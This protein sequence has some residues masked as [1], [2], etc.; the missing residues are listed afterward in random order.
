MRVIAGFLLTAI[1]IFGAEYTTYIGDS[2]SYTVTAMV[3][4]AVGNTYLA[5]S[6]LII[7]TLY[8][9]A[10]TTV[11]YPASDVFVTKLD[12][13]G[14]LLFTVAFAG[15]ISDQAN[16]IA[17]DPSGNIY[18]AGTTYSP[19]FP[20]SNALQ[21]AFAPLGSSFIMKLSP[22]G[23]TIL[24]STFFGG[25][26]P[27]TRINA[28]A[29]DAKGNLYLT[30]YTSASDFPM[31]SGM[32]THSLDPLTVGAFVTEISAAGDK[33]IYSAV[34]TGTRNACSPS[35]GCPARPRST[36]GAGIAVDGGGN[37][38]IAGNTSTTDLA[39]S[40]GAFAAQGIG[41]F[42][43]KIYAGGTGVSYLTYLGAGNYYGPLIE[44][45]TNTVNAV[46]VDSGGSVYLAGA[47]SDPSFPAT[48]GAYQTTFAGPA[49]MN[50]SQA[51]PSDA[52]LAKL[53]PTGT[54]L[55]WATY[56]GGAGMDS[57]NSIAVDADGTVWAVGATT[58]PDFPNANGWLH[59]GNFLAGLSESG[60][61]LTYAAQYPSG[62]VATSVAVDAGGLV[63]AAGPT[64]IVTTIAPKQPP[65]MRPFAIT[66]A[67]GGAVSGRIAR[68]ELISIYGPHIGPSTPVSAMP[69]SAGDLPTSL[70]GIQVTIGGIQAW[71][72]YVSDSQI[73]A[74][75][76]VLAN[77]VEG[78]QITNN[79]N[80]SP[81][82]RVSVVDALP[83]IFKHPDGT[84][85]VI[86]QDGTINSRSN[87]AQ[88]GSVLTFWA[89]GATARQFPGRIAN[90]AS[91]SCE[92]C[93]VKLA[94]T[95]N[96]TIL[97]AGSSPGLPG[98]IM[99]INIL[100]PAKWNY[101]ADLSL[102]VGGEAQQ[103]DPVPFY[104][105]TN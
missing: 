47:T 53:N 102:S 88:P 60:S 77:R 54:A 97:Y 51:A 83:Q 4:D 25:T 104:L 91:N 80:K 76:P 23:R 84:A 48:T 45:P 69:D 72:V 36:V 16:A 94:G 20:L 78:V 1:P 87:P 46:A 14:N 38:Y 22:T 35:S 3:A 96:L 29:T 75:V 39:T 11:T 61:L 105:T 33:I 89:T 100:L 101:L 40:A 32:P 55:L 52:F 71:L 79:G 49:S 37:A 62:T 17:V 56:L 43:A 98:A 12:P 27:V 68:G 21:T 18:I 63:H 10:P 34:I 30:G 5:G 65:T 50:P 85:A 8:N 67:A 58:S 57:A 90:L 103:S 70:G 31:I 82:F 13:S 6:R 73:N 2:Y 64:G 66:S 19:D 41:A 99:Q 86:N 59:G 24:Y 92:T 74:I 15:K 93:S 81:A 26:G 7:P 9:P 28:L 42:V 44:I 95:A